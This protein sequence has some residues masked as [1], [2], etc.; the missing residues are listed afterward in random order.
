MLKFLFGGD[1]EK[2][3]DQ[4]NIKFFPSYDLEAALYSLGK[5]GFQTI[6]I[7]SPLL[8]VFHLFY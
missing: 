1:A 5:F 2:T 3:A 6:P 8:S 4:H 7:G